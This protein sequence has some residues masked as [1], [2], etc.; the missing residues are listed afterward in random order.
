M[1]W[2]KETKEK[3]NKSV[4]IAN[5]TYLILYARPIINDFAK[6]NSAKLH[7]IHYKRNRKNRR[8]LC[9]RKVTM[10]LIS[11]GI[12]IL[13]SIVLAEQNIFAKIQAALSRNKKRK[14]IWNMKD[15]NSNAK[16]RNMKRILI[17]NGWMK[18]R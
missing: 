4:R 3:L 18:P 14:I 6:P 2:K 11:N 8:K 1:E 10:Q 9:C 15:E 16:K 7:W 12:F 17:K 5:I 13:Q